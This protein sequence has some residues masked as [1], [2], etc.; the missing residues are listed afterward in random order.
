VADFEAAFRE[1]ELRR[2]LLS[3]TARLGHPIIDLY[4]LAMRQRGTLKTRAAD[5]V[6]IGLTD[7]EQEALSFTSAILSLLDEQRRTPL[8]DREWAAFDELAAAAMHFDLVLDVNEPNARTK[9]LA[10][11]GRV[12]GALLRQQQPVGGMTG[13][14]GKTLVRQFR[15][16]GYP[17]V[18]LS[19]DLLQEGEDLHTFCSDVY[20]YGLAWTP[21]AVEQRI[22][23]VDR[24]RSK[25]E[26]TAMAVTEALPDEGRLQ[27][28]Y[29]HLEDT[30]ERLQVR[31][32][33]R[34]MHEFIRLMHEGLSGTV[35][36]SSRLNV[37]HEIVGAA[38]LPEPI[39]TPLTT[40]FPVQDSDLV[41]RRR[42]LAITPDMSA[43]IASRLRSFAV[44]RSPLGDAVVWDEAIDEHSL[45][46]TMRLSSGRLQH[47]VL[48][49][50][51][52]SEH[53]VVRCVSPV[54]RLDDAEMIERVKRLSRRVPEQLG[55]IEE[56]DD[57]GVDLTVEEE[58]LLG[59][60]AA[61]ASR[62]AWLVTRVTA[63]ADRLEREL[64]GDDTDSP[65][66]R[67]RAALAREGRTGSHVERT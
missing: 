12:F 51:T 2:E 19:T 61:D 32:V 47:F 26:R 4:V 15:M 22:G 52:F 24:V 18:L 44:S 43:R 64:W 10:E 37:Q 38:D 34:R 25:T 50:D 56:A 23:R 5:A 67:F 27:V 58:V 49:L 7:A 45:P 13:Q 9:P 11:A 30:V 66:D 1:R 39:R 21:S 20:H 59:D 41:G 35:Q 63:A 3:T 6:D 54:G 16:P 28:F 36:E 55:I 29:P 42:A 62:I 31:R 17:F 46:G 14:V 60:P 33:L 40:A 8:D 48:H 57:R 53:L 65:I